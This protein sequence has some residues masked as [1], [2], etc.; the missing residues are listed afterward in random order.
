MN[1]PVLTVIYHESDEHLTMAI[2]A[3]ECF[4]GYTP[5]IVGVVN[6]K[7]Y[8]AHYPSYVTY[9]E[10][11]ENCLASAWNKGLTELFK[12]HDY[13]VVSG[14][15]SMVRPEILESLEVLVEQHPDAGL[16]SI[17]P[18]AMAGGTVED[19][20]VPIR[21]GDGSFSFFIISKK[22]FGK[23]GGFDERYKPAYFEDNDYLERCWQAGY[24]PVR[25]QYLTYYHIFQ[26]TMKYGHDSFK[27]YPIYMQDNLEL[28]KSTYGKVPD[29]LPSD[30][31]FYLPG[32]IS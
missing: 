8:S 31:T 7:L 10:N 23:V 30:I 15:D 25:H 29:H 21:H 20:T 18:E 32:K 28:F 26:G 27:N 1:Y 14:L 12:R 22:L 19:T 6:K 4:E 13:V 11:D 16:W 24:T 17:T 9:I 2:R 3:W 5:E